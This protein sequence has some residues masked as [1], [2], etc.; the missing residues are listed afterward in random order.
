MKPQSK[1]PSRRL[2]G[3][4]ASF[5][6]QGEEGPFYL[7]PDYKTEQDLSLIHI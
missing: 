4:P 7:I 5:Q 3:D 6:P 1:Y 2:E